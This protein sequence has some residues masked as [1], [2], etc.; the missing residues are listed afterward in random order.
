MAPVP[1][2]F[3]G[4]NHEA[5]NH[6]WELYYGGWAAPNIYYLGAAGCIK[7]G[8]LRIAGLSGTYKPVRFHWAG[9]FERP[10]QGASP[11]FQQPE[12]LYLSF[13]SLPRLISLCLKPHWTPSAPSPEPQVQFL[14][15]H[16][17][18]LPYKD[19]ALKSI[20]GI[21]DWEVHRLMQLTQPLDIFLTHDW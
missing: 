10:T 4:G 11:L 14:K 6:S 17:E 5:A 16:D 18:R 12:P 2:L 15:G 20:Y 7:F 13:P 19:S 21:R 1:T 8:G 3:I 9:L